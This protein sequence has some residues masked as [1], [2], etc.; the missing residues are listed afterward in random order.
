MR[1]IT[2]FINQVI[3]LVF[4][5]FLI[6]PNQSFAQNFYLKAGAGLNA[7]IG[8][9]T[10]RGVSFQTT[11]GGQQKIA[12]VDYPFGTSG[13]LNLGLFYRLTEQFHIGIEG[14][15]RTTNN[16][17]TPLDS[18]N[19]FFSTDGRRSRE[20]YLWSII[21]QVKYIMCKKN[22]HTISSFVG[23]LLSSGKITEYN[24]N[25]DLNSI[26]S[27]S[28]VH[29]ETGG[30]SVGVMAGLEYAFSSKLK[31]LD[32]YAQ[33][34]L[35][36]QSYA[37]KKRELTILI[38]NNE[39]VLPTLSVSERIT[40]LEDSFIINPNP[41]PDEPAKALRQHYP[42]SSIGLNIGLLVKLG[43]VKDQ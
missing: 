16:L 36:T 37:P 14:T 18:N 19:I 27:Y 41:S 8:K 6:I 28:E 34:G 29:E 5:F 17:T 22:K 15:Y 39:N 23:I 40:D 38:L 3:L 35:I 25:F 43:K 24:F 13:Q 7:G 1:L 31:F 20:A 4:C 2:D 32:F 21:P 11:S 30:L 26:N 12:A 33:L 10:V 9:T 42:F